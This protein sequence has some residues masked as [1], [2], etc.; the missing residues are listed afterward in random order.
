[1]REH[2]IVLKGFWDTKNEREQP[3]KNVQHKKHNYKHEYNNDL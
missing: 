1:M 2:D 3:T